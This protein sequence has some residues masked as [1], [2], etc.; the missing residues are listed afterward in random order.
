MAALALPLAHAGHWIEGLAFG[1]P[2]V[3]IPL[4]LVTM[5]LMERKRERR[6]AGAG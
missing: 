6:S 3:L 2:A 1:L 5:V 4:A